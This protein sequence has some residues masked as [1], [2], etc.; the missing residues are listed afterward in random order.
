MNHLS[1][2]I[3][4]V[5]LILVVCF[6]ASTIH[7]DTVTINFKG[8]TDRS[9]FG[10][11]QQTGFWGLETTTDVS[12]FFSYDSDLVDSLPA[13]STIDKFVSN[14]PPLNVGLGWTLSFTVGSTTR[15]V[16]PSS[17][18]NFSLFDRTVAGGDLYSFTGGGNKASIVLNDTLAGGNDAIQNLTGLAPQFAPDLSLFDGSNVGSYT[19]EG[20]GNFLKFQITEM[21]LQ[22]PTNPIPEPTTLLLLGSG[23][24]GVAL[25][26]RR[27]NRRS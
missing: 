13:S 16:D 27:S 11:S 6:A 4:V 15:D 2:A 19:V 5:G 12:G 1:Q 18:F 20:L 22:A 14:A 7:A 8:T 23:L 9:I 24:V 25:K 21:T 17:F 26:R 10:T 3:T